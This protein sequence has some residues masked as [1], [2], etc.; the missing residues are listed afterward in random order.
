VIRA[1]RTA[2][3]TAGLAALH[4]LTPRQARDVQPWN[5]EGH[6][7]RVTTGTRSKG[8]PDLWDTEQAAAFAQGKPVPDLPTVDDPDDLLDRNEC[9]ALIEVTAK[10]WTDYQSQGKVPK[11]DRV[12]CG[13]EHWYRRTVETVRDKREQQAG[14]PH[15]GRPPG[16]TESMSRAEV[17]QRI[18]ELV[19]SGVTNVAEIQRRVGCAYSTALRHVR[20]LRPQ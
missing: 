7:P 17:A 5:A 19:G 10:T 3:D 13:R 11:P 6:P 16:S 12:V 1:G 4:G 18:G 20:R 8:Q 9:A 15:G 2:V 14:T